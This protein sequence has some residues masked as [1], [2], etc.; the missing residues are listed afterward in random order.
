[1]TFTPNWFVYFALFAWPL[2]VIALYRT[3]PAGKA[4]IWAIL[5]GYL[6][7]PVGTV[8]KIP[9]I[10]QFDKDSIP[11]LTAFIAAMFVLRRPVRIW[12]GFGVPEMLIAGLLVRSVITSLLNDDYI[13]IGMLFLPGL[14][15]Y[16]AGSAI[17]AQFIILIPFFLGRQILRNAIDTKD[18]LR[19]LAVAGLVYS[20]PMLLEIRL[21][22]QLHVWIYGYF[23][24]E[25]SQQM[26]AGGFRPVVFLGHGLMVAFLAMTSFVAAAA[27]WRVD[28]KIARF[29]PA[30]VTAYL[31]IVLFLCKTLGALVYGAVLMLLVRWASPRLQV[32]IASLLVIIAIGYPILRAGDLVPTEMMLELASLVSEERAGSLGT[33]FSQEH[34]LLVRA[35]E[36]FWFG[37]GRYGRSRIYDEYGSDKTQSDGHWVITMGQFGFVGFL[38]EFGLLALTVIRANS[39]FRRAMSRE[40]RLLVS[41]LALIVAI[42]IFDLIPNATIRPWTWLVAGALM[43]QVEKLKLAVTNRSTPKAVASGPA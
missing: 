19:A 6:L 37:W 33:R 12:S 38:V 35:S 9:M 41:A 23:P 32:R 43:G 13:Q 28:V 25:F 31:G 11:A 17:M 20:L 10:P 18:I 14:G 29:R 26:R 4:T 36:R 5:G 15:S 34:D 8:I 7:L 30:G 2:V 1:M 40:D 42:S 16:E 21:S 39:I 24:H 22:P 27:L 3:Q